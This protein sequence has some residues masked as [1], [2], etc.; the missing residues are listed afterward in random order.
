MFGKYFKLNSAVIIIATVGGFL[1]YNT[2]APCTSPITYKI[3][4]FDTNFGISKQDFLKDINKASSLWSNAVNKALFAYDEKGS[5]TINLIY[6]NRQ[7]TTV[8]NAALKAD[9]Q[10]IA[11][12]AVGVRQEYEQLEANYAQEKSDYAAAVTTFN[13]AQTNYSNQVTYWNT[14][15]G[16]PNDEYV[17]LNEQ[18][19]QL[20][21]QQNTLEA[22]RAQINSLVEQ[23]NVFI[24]RY[25]LLIT[26]ANSRISTINKSAGKEFEEGQYD[27]ST[28][29]ITIYEFGDN[30]KLLRVLAHEL[31]HSLDINHN[32]NPNSIMYE[33]NKG[34]NFALSK[35]DIASLKTVCKL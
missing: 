35:E 18:R 14:H 5:L 21:K 32:T 24:Q 20:I 26:D 19:A 30:K 33:L 29:S 11:Q 10:K 25:N 22:K 15:G 23:I 3:G 31:G 12:L 2:H 9:S 7:K 28:N 6:D 1:Y 17:Q 16:A 27:P 34:T 8:Q 4:T 13:T